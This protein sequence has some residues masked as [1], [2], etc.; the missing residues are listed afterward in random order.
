MPVIETMADGGHDAAYAAAHA[1]DL[2][3]AAFDWLSVGIV[4]GVMMS[5]VSPV[6]QVLTVIWLSI[7]IWQSETVV[8]WRRR[9]RI[10]RRRR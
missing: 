6:A 3:R 8:N 7:R 9:W 4:A 5:I 10:W 2:G 1:A